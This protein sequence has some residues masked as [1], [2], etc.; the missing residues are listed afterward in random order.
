MAIQHSEERRRAPRIPVLVRVECRTPQNYIVGNCRNISET[1]MLIKSRQVFEVPQAV[2]LRF[3]LPPISTGKVIQ[4]GATV[5]RVAEE[6]YMAVKFT[7]LRPP[8]RDAIA[9]FVERIMGAG[10]PPKGT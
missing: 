5:V 6:G 8:L 10:E 4:A 7:D 3:A 9:R 1:G 2:T